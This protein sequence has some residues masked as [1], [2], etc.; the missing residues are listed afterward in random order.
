MIRVRELG[1]PL[2]P[3]LAA[4]S[5]KGVVLLEF[6]DRRAIEAQVA[7]LRRRM[8]LPIVPGTNAV[9]ERPARELDEYFAGTRA[10]RR[11]AARATGT[12]FQEAVWKELRAIPPGATRSYADVRAHSAA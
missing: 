3:M 2:G 1:T 11:A 5:G 6:V 8:E 12:P 10:L 9:L 7:T 4:A